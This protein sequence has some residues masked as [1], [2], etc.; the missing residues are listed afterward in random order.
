MTVTL[1]RFDANDSLAIHYLRQTAQDPR[2][3]Q[4][5]ES[6]AQAYRVAER[7]DEAGHAFGASVQLT[8]WILMVRIRYL[9]AD[10]IWTAAVRN[11]GYIE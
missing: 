1:A 8:S 3:S 6:P 9:M 7:L 4:A 11:P 5:L 10:V 2:S